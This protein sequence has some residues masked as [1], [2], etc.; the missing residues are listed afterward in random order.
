M[1]TR[2]K[3]RKAVI[4][5][6]GRGVRM[7]PATKSYPKEMFP[8]LGTPVL[9]YVVEEAVRSGITDIL[10]IIGKRKNAIMD[11]FNRDFELEN[12]LA[13]KGKDDLLKEIERISNLA[14]IYFTYQKESKGL[15]DAV[16]YA[17][18]F[19]GNEP[20][21]LLLG[22]NIFYSKTPCTA[23]LISIFDRYRVS[24]IMVEKV[25]EFKVSRYGIIK[26]R[27]IGE[28]LFEIE[29]LVEKPSLEEAPSNFAIGGRY[30]LTPDIFSCI[31]RTPPGRGGEVQITDALRLL[32]RKLGYITEGK[33]YDI[34]DKLDYLKAQIE[35]GLKREEFRDEL[36]EYL[37]SLCK[38]VCSEEGTCY[39]HQ[40]TDKSEDR[41][42][43]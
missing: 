29:D 10:M 23:Q 19:I 37:E 14:N 11:Y 6:A 3:V 38:N 26:G 12:H 24:V 18:E 5:V 13:Q 22:D 36:R 43:W 27:K 41:S 21:A 1:S 34:G 17:E 30:I 39:D 15:G 25:P 7:L 35:L 16:S 28:R 9:Q 20:F 4:P 8:I 40:K 2:G 31:R 42:N 32:N 33:R